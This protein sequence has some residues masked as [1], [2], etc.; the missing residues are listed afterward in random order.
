MTMAEGKAGPAF[1]SRCGE[2]L[3][4]GARFC[5]GCGAAVIQQTASVPALPPPHP[6]PPVSMQP[7]KKRKNRHWGV[8]LTFETIACGAFTVLTT[9]VGAPPIFVGILGIAAVLFFIALVGLLLTRVARRATDKQVGSGVALA[10]TTGYSPDG[11]WFWDGTKWIPVH[12]QPAPALAAPAVL[13]A[14]VKSKKK[15]K[16]GYVLMLLVIAAVLGFA[17]WW[18]LDW[19][20]ILLIAGV[21]LVLAATAW[22][23]P[24]GIGAAI[25]KVGSKLKL[26]GIR[27]GATGRKAALLLALDLALLPV[28]VGAWSTWEQVFAP[29]PVQLDGFAVMA[30]PLTSATVTAYQ[31]NS[32]GSAVTIL[33]TATT[34]K[35]GHYT[36]PVTLPRHT[37]VLLATTGG[38]Y[39]DQVT[40]KPVAAIAGDS[41]RSIL[42][43]DSGQVSLTPL[44]TFA[45]SRATTLAWAGGNLDT[46]IAASYSAVANDYGLP[47]VSETYPAIAVEAPETQPEI[48]N[49]PSRQMGLALS[50]L[51]EEASSLG[52]SDFALTNALASDI[53]DGKFD[54]KA[55]GKAGL[56]AIGI[57]RTPITMLP[58]DAPHAADKKKNSNPNNKLNVPTPDF[59]AG[60]VGLGLNLGGLDFISTS[61][62]PAWRSDTQGSATIQGS[63]GTKP[64]RCSLAGGS[65]LPPGFTLSSDCVLTGKGVKTTNTSI[66]AGFT[67]TMTDS[68]HPN[69]L[70]SVGLNI[71]TT[72]FPPKPKINGGECPAVNQPCKILDFATATGGTPPYSYQK[73]IMAPFPP[74]GMVLWSDGSLRGTPHVAGSSKSFS[75]CAVDIG[76]A[77]G[78][79]S[80][81]FTTMSPPPPGPSPS[82]QNSTTTYWYL[83][84]R[85]HKDPIGVGD[86]IEANACDQE[87]INYGNEIGQL[88]DVGQ[89]TF[90]LPTLQTC[91]G[92]ANKEIAAVGGSWWCNQDPHGE[93]TQP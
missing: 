54:G 1:C 32:G 71:T 23:N 20:Y 90:F 70:K 29:V 4:P 47:D 77:I 48:L 93:L 61:S 45:T 56:A 3:N 59:F 41:L 63:G 76:G 68:S 83:H 7:A 44:S 82:P 49:L 51:N 92:Q 89:G 65:T 22:W 25:T 84:F 42:L 60:P 85:C 18:Y 80:G 8:I 58:A 73:E 10:L 14:A 35:T 81:S 43:A 21:G 74:L 78:C 27:S 34:D 38:T 64:Y 17:A 16:T 13:V 19:Y 86:N 31:L 62:L 2:A 28:G 11:A 55:P 39:V 88:T 72:P 9:Y 36:L 15:T 69:I 33:G 53:S 79:T 37:H 50:G 6:S 12:G 5:A 87:S 26:P 24:R 75:V 30:N 91:Q 40:N 57:N 52:V 66:S 67:V 46:S